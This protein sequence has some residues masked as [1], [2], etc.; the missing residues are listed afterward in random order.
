MVA[1]LSGR[2]AH[3]RMDALLAAA[4]DTVGRVDFA[5]FDAD[6]FGAAAGGGGSDGG[7]GLLSFG[8]GAVGSCLRDAE[9]FDSALFRV[10]AGEAAFMDP[11]QR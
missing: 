6:A 1:A 4:E 3:G 11:N 9:L 8:G 7:D 10:S 2:L 5:R